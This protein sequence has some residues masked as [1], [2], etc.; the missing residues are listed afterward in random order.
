[1][2]TLIG[3]RVFVAKSKSWMAGANPA[4]TVFGRLG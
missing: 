1:M 4:M 2:R 3:G